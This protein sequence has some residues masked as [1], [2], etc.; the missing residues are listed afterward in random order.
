MRKQTLIAGPAFILF[1]I[2]SIF[3][4]IQSQTNWLEQHEKLEL[5]DPFI[6]IEYTVQSNY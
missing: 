3:I 1:T 2:F 4:S 5:N 6:A